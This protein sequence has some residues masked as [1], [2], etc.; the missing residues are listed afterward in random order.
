VKDFNKRKVS[1]TGF[2]L[3]LKVQSGKV[4]EFLILKDQSLC[5]YGAT[6]KM[7]E[8]VS[9]KVVGDGVKAIMDEPVSVLGTLHV[10]AIR[11]SG[12]LIGIYSMEGEKLIGPN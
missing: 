1:L 9:V 3:P 8:W 11:E 2:M 5:C 12:Y 6:P 7:N 4:T 10:G